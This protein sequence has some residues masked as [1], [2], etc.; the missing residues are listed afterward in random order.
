MDNLTKD[1]PLLPVYARA[2]P[3]FSHGE[4]SRL[5]TRDGADYI[6]C[7]GGIATNALGHAHPALIAAL[8]GQ[9]RKLWHLSNMFRIPGQE[10]LASKLVSETFADRVFFTNS[11]SEAIECALKMARRYHYDKGRPE[12]DVV[13]G[14]S[15]SFHGRSYA[16]MNAAG[17]PVHCEG[18]GLRLPGY[19][20]LSLDDSDGIL[21]AIADPRTA[22]I[23]V[24]PVQGEGG[25]RE[26]PC[27]LLRD[28]RIA[29]R[30][31]GVL[32]IYDEVQSGMGRT[33]KLFAHQWYDN[34]EPDLMAVA[35]ALG[36]GFPLG[37]CL[38]TKAVASAMVPGTHG[39]TFGGNPLAMA[40]GN[41]AFDII[42]DTATLHR[43]QDAEQIMRTGLA[44]IAEARPEL[45]GE[46]RGK[47][48]LIGIALKVPNREFMARALYHRL[49][50]GGGGGNIVRLLPALNISDHEI[51]DVLARFDATCTD[52][53]RSHSENR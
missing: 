42:N 35:K 40:V 28:I 41:A 38:A 22:A 18:F 11:G 32:L 34:I 20:Q 17:N 13:Y 43:A 27:Q 48:L 2:D 44:S 19:G 50:V 24:E 30:G 29:T 5:F 52:M 3:V 12:R 6:D 26:V 31:A 9:A 51:D 46:V 14:F 47:G 1:S 53:K 7:V 16:A 45:I 25:A 36:C 23:I 8:E 39:S 15:G 4:G 33:G 49:L 10:E 21:T 37:A